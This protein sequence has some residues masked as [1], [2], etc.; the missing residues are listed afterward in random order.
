ME[1]RKILR[2]REICGV[3]VGAILWILFL[4]LSLTNCVNS[5][6]LTFLA[7]VF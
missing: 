7:A 1:C 3:R 6:G 2:R 4:N 5:F